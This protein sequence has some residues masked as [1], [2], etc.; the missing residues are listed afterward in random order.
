MVYGPKTY[1]GE[2]LVLHNLQQKET[3]FRLTYKVDAMI[4]V[5]LSETL[6]EDKSMIS[7]TTMQT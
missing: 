2:T 6:S 7:T 5:E 1:C 3:H 4:L